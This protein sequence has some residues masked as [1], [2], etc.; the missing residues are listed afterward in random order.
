MSRTVVIADSHALSNF[1]ACPRKYSTLFITKITP[2]A[3]PPT[4]ITEGTVIHAL[5]SLYYRQRLAGNDYKVAGI[6]ALKFI[7]EDFTSDDKDIIEAKQLFK[8][9]TVELQSLIMQKFL[10]YIQYYLTD[11]IHPIT[12]EKGFSKII[13]E[14]SNYLFIYEG[15][16]DLV[17]REGTDYYWMDHK[18][19]R[20]K[21]P[22]PHFSNQ[23]LGYSWALNC[24]KGIINYIGFQESKEPKECF[25]RE[26]VTHKPSQIEDWKKDIIQ[27]YFEIVRCKA[28]ENFPKYRAS[29]QGKYAQCSF[30][31]LCNQT[32][33]LVINHMIK[34][35]FTEMKWSP[36]E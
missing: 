7:R 15:R 26:I 21:D 17:A 27:T 5:L 12:T 20:R 34:T 6:E 33:P 25:H 35:Q 19:Q 16:I 32:S 10:Q 36:W 2:K 29:C 9:F 30:Y 3:D 31:E 22:L 11:N 24:Y 23:F 8:S 4:Y 14:D 18:K 28:N 1:Q 13:Y